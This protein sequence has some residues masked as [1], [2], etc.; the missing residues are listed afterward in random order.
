MVAYAV[1]AS[2]WSMVTRCA[3]QIDPCIMM[4]SACC[5]PSAVVHTTYRVGD[6]EFEDNKNQAEDMADALNEAH[7][8]NERRGED[9]VLIYPGGGY[10]KKFKGECF[11]S[12][13]WMPCEEPYQKEK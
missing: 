9:G 12:T 7:W 13:G 1:H 10:K 5:N 3:G 8:R 6:L 11:E 2:T 4:G